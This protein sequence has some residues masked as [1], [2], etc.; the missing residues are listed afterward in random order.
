MQ[1]VLLVEL[2]GIVDG[3]VAIAVLAIEVE[4]DFVH[5]ELDDVYLALTYR[6]V[7]T[8]ERVQ[9]GLGCDCRS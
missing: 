5:E 1:D 9:C 2:V 6:L 4:V 7:I 3:T 8:R